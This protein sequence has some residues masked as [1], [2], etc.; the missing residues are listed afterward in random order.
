[1]IVW[2]SSPVMEHMENDFLSGVPAMRDCGVIPAKK[3]VQVA[4]LIV[5]RY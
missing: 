2:A 5:A 1:M 3:T 4:T